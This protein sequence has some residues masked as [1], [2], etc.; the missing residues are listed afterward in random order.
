MLT[1]VEKVI[2]LQDVDIFEHTLTED[3]AHIAAITEE[4]NFPEKSIIYQENDISDSMY[5]VIQGQ[6]QLQRNG[7]NVMIARRKDVFGTWALLD[8]EPRVVT[9]QTIEEAKLL[10][11]ERD[12]FF[13]LLADHVH[14]T[15]SILKANAKRL[16]HLMQ[17]V[18]P[19]ITGTQT[20]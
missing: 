3:L 18:S 7:Q 9:A 8:D 17:I 12:D 19:Q 10:R 1:I 20:P 16:R 5:L 2:F 6:V 15:Q 4:V 13:D 11:I 14:I